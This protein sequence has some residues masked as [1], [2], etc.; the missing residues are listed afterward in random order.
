MGRIEG[1]AKVLIRSHKARPN[2][3]SRSNEGIF[4][5]KKASHPDP[6]KKPTVYCAITHNIAQ[7]AGFVQS[8]DTKPK[9]R[10]FE[11]LQSQGMQANQQLTFLSDGGDTVR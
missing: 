7:E 6:S 5:G 2:W 8:Y 11:V 3:P 1:V 4:Y 10:L 9:R